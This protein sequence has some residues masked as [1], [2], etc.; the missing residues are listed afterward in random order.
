MTTTLAWVAVILSIPVLILL[1]ASESKQQKAR[2]WRRQ[3]WTQKR[4]ADRLH[5]STSTVR[6]Y[7]A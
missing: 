2:R 1:W 5:V 7:C 6:R 4:I 3:G